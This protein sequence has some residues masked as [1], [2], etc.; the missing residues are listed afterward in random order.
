MTSTSATDPKFLVRYTGCGE[1]HEQAKAAA[2]A[3]HIPLNSFILQ[4]IDEKLNRGKVMDRLLDMAE[5]GLN[6]TVINVVDQDPEAF[7][8]VKQAVRDSRLT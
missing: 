3:A 4:A 5:A 2:K 8:R 7:E 1:M 6:T